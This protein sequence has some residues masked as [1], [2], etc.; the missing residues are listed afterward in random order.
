MPSDEQIMERI[1]QLEQ[2]REAL[3]RD[4]SS[5]HGSVAGDVSRLEE[6]GVE[7]DRLWD[8]RRQRQALR[9]AGQDPDTAKER[10]ADTVERYWQ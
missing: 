8:L 6:I 9:D 3:R 4:E 5:T 10:S 2:E 7:L 1:E